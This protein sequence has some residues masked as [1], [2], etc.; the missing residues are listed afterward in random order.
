MTNSQNNTDENIVLEEYTESSSH[1]SHHRHRSSGKKEKK[2]KNSNL[3]LHVDSKGNTTYKKR[4]SLKSGITKKKWF[5]IANRICIIILVLILILLLAALIYYLIAKHIGKN[6]LIKGN[7]EAVITTIDGAESTDD[8]HTVTYK[9][10]TYKYNEDVASIVIMGI[11]QSELENEGG[12]AGRADAI[13]IF[14][15]DT[16]TGKCNLIPVSRDTMADV[17]IRSVSGE[18]LGYE[19]LQLA[20]SYSYGDGKLT[21][22]ENTTE[23]LSRI[24]YNIPF[25]NYIALDWDAIAP[26]NDAIGGVHLKALEDINTKYTQNKKGDKVTLTGNDAWSYVKYRDTSRLDSNPLRIRRQKQYLSAFANKFLPMAREDITIVSDLYNTASDYMYTNLSR[27]TVVYIVSEMLPNVYSAKD[28]TQHNI[29]GELTMGEKF[30]EF[31]PDETSL[32]ETIL[33]VYY[34]KQ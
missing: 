23:T 3:E 2:K 33:K 31:V 30:A 26:L 27:E 16:N 14:T 18:D 11:D 12:V 25:N 20:L 28:I 9:G 4:K 1:H 24:F 22:C 29:K 5:K 21:S 13:Y 6:N 8:G 34:I 17:K 10:D 19:K 15:Y 7:K 32:Y